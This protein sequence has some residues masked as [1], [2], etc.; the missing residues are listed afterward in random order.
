M[1][2]WSSKESPIRETVEYLEAVL[3][4]NHHKS[5]S[6]YPQLK[7]VLTNQ[8]RHNNARYAHSVQLT[9]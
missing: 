7:L 4:H 9:D 8:S 2:L 6:Q 1:F 3:A 5:D